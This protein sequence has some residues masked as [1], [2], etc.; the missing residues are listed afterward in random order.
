MYTLLT[1][2]KPLFI[3]VIAQ[4][5]CVIIRQGLLESYLDYFITNNLSTSFDQIDPKN[6]N[7]VAIVMQMV[8]K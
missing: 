2:S 6:V 3:S 5:W 4:I 1:K 7:A 8:P